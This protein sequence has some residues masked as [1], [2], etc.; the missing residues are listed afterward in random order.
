[1]S[2]LPE[3]YALALGT[4]TAVTV[5]SL[6]SK[7]LLLLRCLRNVLWRLCFQNAAQ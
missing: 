7:C 4:S 2:P 1:L 3:G 6:M 5:P